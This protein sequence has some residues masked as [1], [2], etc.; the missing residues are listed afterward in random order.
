M[1]TTPRFVCHRLIPCFSNRPQILPWLIYRTDHTGDPSAKA[2]ILIIYDIFGLSAP[3]KQG[4][5]I[6]SHA[7]SDHQI[8]VFVP[9]FFHGNTLPVEIFPPDT[10]EKKEQL[11]AF[12]G[13]PAKPVS[14][15]EKIPGILKS[16]NEQVPGIKRWALLGMCWGGKVYPIFNKVPDVVM[17]LL[18]T[19]QIRRL[20]LCHPQKERLSP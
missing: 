4:A 9:D 20:C 19:M 6:L 15:V 1:S 16:L 14:T 5:D 7:Q 3:V 8:Q 13:G 2:A 12:F 18:T 11:G 17:A 10:P